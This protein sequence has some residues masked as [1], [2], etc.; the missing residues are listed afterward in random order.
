MLLSLTLR[1]IIDEMDL[2]VYSS[3]LLSRD[4][5]GVSAKEESTVIYFILQTFI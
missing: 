1:E 5:R 4:G 2:H 3:M